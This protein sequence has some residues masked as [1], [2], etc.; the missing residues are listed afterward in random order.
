MTSPSLAALRT[1]VGKTWGDKILYVDFQE[2]KRSL[3]KGDM[4][5]ANE[6]LKTFGV[7]AVESTNGK[8]LFTYLNTGETYTPTLVRQYYPTSRVLIT[9]M[10]DQIE[11]LERKGV[12]VY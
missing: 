12:E 1:L 5:R 7:E 8:L 3:S 9:S 2:L 6:I 4:R 11:W 10:G